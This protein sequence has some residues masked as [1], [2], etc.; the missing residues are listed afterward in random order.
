N[1][2]LR[3]GSRV[4]LKLYPHSG[5]VCWATIE[6]I[7]N[8]GLQAPNCCKILARTFPASPPPQRRILPLPTYARASHVVIL[9]NEYCAT[10]CCLVFNGLLNSCSGISCPCATSSG[11]PSP[12]LDRS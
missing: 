6:Y 12:S 10:L 1:I 2:R 11:A 5:N 7:S 9:P 4:R 8:E 3:L